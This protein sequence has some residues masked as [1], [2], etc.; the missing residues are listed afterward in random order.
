MREKERALH[1]REERLR[2]LEAELEHK[3]REGTREKFIACLVSL[4]MQDVAR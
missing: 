2:R 4:R 1:E 3:H